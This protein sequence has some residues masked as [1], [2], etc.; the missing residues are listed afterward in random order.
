MKEAIFKMLPEE[1]TNEDVLSGWQ[2]KVELSQEEWKY[3]LKH[4]DLLEDHE[5][6]L[7]Y[8]HQDMKT[9]EEGGKKGIKISSFVRGFVDELDHPMSAEDFEK[10]SKL[11]ALWDRLELRGRELK[12]ARA[13]ARE[14]SGDLTEKAECIHTLTEKIKELEEE[15][16]K[17]KR[18]EQ[19]SNMNLPEVEDRQ[20]PDE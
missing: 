11:S 20:E 9:W 5:D 13:A 7:R 2:I 3:I 1:S 17:L 15:I 14:L 8:E 19:N 4:I 6:Q 16:E 18:T 12:I 10:T